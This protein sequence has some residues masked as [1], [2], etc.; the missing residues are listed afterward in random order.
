MALTSPRSPLFGARFANLHATRLRLR[1]RPE[2]E[3]FA[4]RLSDCVNL[5]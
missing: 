1:G 3:P 5:G 4:T 2:A